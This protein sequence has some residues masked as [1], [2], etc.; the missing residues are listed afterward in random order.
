M[1]VGQDWAQTLRSQK[2]QM[3]RLRILYF[4]KQRFEVPNPGVL[5]V[6]HVLNI[7]EV[8][9]GVLLAPLHGD[10]AGDWKALKKLL[11]RSNA[12]HCF[13]HKVMQ[14]EFCCSCFLYGPSAASTTHVEMSA[15]CHARR[16][17]A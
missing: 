2:G 11:E 15:A 7:V 9:E 3:L 17:P 14:A 8:V 6:A 1:R 12:L 13:L 4:E 16:S 10:A 5:H